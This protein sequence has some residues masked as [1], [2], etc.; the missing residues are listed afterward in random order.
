[1]QP[2]IANHLLSRREAAA[3]LAISPRKLD[4]L[5]AEGELPRIKIGS[6]VRF[7]QTDLDAF[8]ADQKSA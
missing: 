3:F 4:S 8:I 1:M 7:E 2:L 5:V 6:C